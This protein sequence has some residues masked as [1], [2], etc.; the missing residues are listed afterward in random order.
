MTRGWSPH[1]KQGKKSLA[2]STQPATIFDRP[3]QMM[4]R[5]PPMTTRF[6]AISS[7]R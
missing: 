4:G 6:M 5:L 3:T 2:S 7:F 1:M